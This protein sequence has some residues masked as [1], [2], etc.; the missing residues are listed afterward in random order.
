MNLRGV[1][2]D[3]ATASELLFEG[4]G[5]L[6]FLFMLERSGLF[7]WLATLDCDRC[8]SLATAAALAAAEGSSLVLVKLRAFP[9][10]YLPFCRLERNQNVECS[11]RN[12]LR[13]VCL[14][15]MRS[16][17]NDWKAVTQ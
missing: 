14:L 15:M 13:L 7:A 6:G 10:P 12:R 8:F 4:S 11:N 9:Q 5:G 1:A 3:D 17:P 2:F 16:V